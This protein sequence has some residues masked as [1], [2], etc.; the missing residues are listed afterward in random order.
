MYLQCSKY[1]SIH[2]VSWHAPGRTS[3][4]LSHLPLSSCL[5]AFWKAKQLASVFLQSLLV[6]SALGLCHVFW[7]QSCICP[8]CLLWAG[9]PD[10]QIHSQVAGR[11]LY[12]IHNK[13]Y[14]FNIY[15]CLIGYTASD[16]C[17]SY[18]C[19]GELWKAMGERMRWQLWKSQKHIQPSLSRSEA[20]LQTSLCSQAKGLAFSQTA[21][22]SRVNRVWS[23][24]ICVVSTAPSRAEANV[25]VC[26]ASYSEGFGAAF[27][28]VALRPD[29]GLCVL[30]R[31]SSNL[32]WDEAQ[33]L[34]N[35]CQLATAMVGLDTCTEV[36][37]VSIM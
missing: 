37:L 22:A 36:P 9:C 4:F 29:Q 8:S 12:H 3:P 13:R 32:S 2:E 1:A 21:I 14:F 25:M 17:F 16:F 20:S 35:C 10:S 26:A 18:Q 33:L 34:W 19:A 5:S 31:W 23:G 6:S 27:W 15:I 7:T 24:G 30:Q 28:C 11:G